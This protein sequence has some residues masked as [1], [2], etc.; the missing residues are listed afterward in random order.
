MEYASGKYDDTDNNVK[1]EYDKYN[2]EA[3]NI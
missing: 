2:S 1:T 3:N